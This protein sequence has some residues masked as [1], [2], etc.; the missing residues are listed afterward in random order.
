MDSELELSFLMLWDR[1]FCGTHTL[2]SFLR[3]FSANWNRVYFP[4]D[5]KN[6]NI[7]LNGNGELSEIWF[8]YKTDSHCSFS[9]FA[10]IRWISIKNVYLQMI[11]HILPIY[12]IQ[13]NNFRSFNIVDTKE[14]VAAAVASYTSIYSNMLANKLNGRN[15]DECVWSIL[16]FMYFPWDFRPSS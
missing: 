12:Y 10:G 13:C 5:I 4:Q 9:P 7:V 8:E 3:K 2:I 14:T 6:Q 15:D 16:A 1:H 11:K